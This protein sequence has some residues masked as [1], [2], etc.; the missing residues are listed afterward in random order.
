[1]GAQKKASYLGILKKPI[2]PAGWRFLPV[3]A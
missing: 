2:D 3:T 1:M